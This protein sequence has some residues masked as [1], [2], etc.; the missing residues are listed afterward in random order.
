[1]ADK[2]LSLVR[3]TVFTAIDC[4]NKAHERSRMSVETCDAPP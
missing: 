2:V 1:M 4:Q 3:A